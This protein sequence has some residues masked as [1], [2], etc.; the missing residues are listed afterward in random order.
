MYL[1]YAAVLNLPL[2]RA[3]AKEKLRRV[4]TAFASVRSR[5]IFSGGETTIKDKVA[6]QGLP[7]SDKLLKLT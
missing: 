4:A 5:H 1:G 3:E 7:E 2:R 6:L